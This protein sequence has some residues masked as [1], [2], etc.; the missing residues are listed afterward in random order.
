M[1]GYLAATIDDA[2]FQPS[3]DSMKAGRLSNVNKSDGYDVMP[4]R[5]RDLAV[6]HD[7]LPIRLQGL[8]APERGKP[9]RRRWARTPLE[10]G[11]LPWM[12]ARSSGREPS[13]CYKFATRSV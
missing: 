11:R 1:E 10:V 3:T 5:R 4:R 2:K 13:D 9:A 8:A 7:G 6:P 12:S